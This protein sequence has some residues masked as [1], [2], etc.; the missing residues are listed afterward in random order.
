VTREG[1]RAIPVYFPEQVY[2]SL[3]ERKLHTRVP[4][5][6]LVVRYVEDG[7]AADRL[8]EQISDD[9]KEQTHV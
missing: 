7:L 6:Q 8:A 3:A 1:E 4:M 9:L 5:T 2:E